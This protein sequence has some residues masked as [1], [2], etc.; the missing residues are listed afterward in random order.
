M[1]DQQ[2]QQSLPDVKSIG[3]G[4]KRERKPSTQH[5]ERVGTG[6]DPQAREAGAGVAVMEAPA[7]RVKRKRRRG[8]RGKLNSKRAKKI[9]EM[10]ERGATLVMAAQ[11]VGVSAATISKWYSRGCDE[12]DGKYRQFVGMVQR[13]ENKGLAAAASR[14]TL[15]GENGI[16]TADAWMLERRR[17]ADYGRNEMTV[18]HTGQV[19]HAVAVSYVDA[20]I[21][22][23]SQL[24]QLAALTGLVLAQPAIETTAKP[25][26]PPK[27]P[28]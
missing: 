10:L 20:S 2:P 13:A 24:A 15:A 11:A 27:L 14:I 21:L 6:D 25:V 18:N 28:G 16:W 23:P 8:A 19:N 17:R 12:A 22:S 26:D 7:V 1:E 9:C 3:P 4:P 5:A